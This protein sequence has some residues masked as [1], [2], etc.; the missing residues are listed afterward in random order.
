MMGTLANKGLK[1]NK[2]P[3]YDETSFNVVKKCLGQLYDPIKFIFD[4]LLYEGMLP[5]D[6]KLELFLF[7]NENKD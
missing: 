4:L 5:D 3:G 1:I 6:L 7:L 2:S